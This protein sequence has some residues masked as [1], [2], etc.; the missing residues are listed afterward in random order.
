MLSGGRL[1]IPIFYH[2]DARLQKDRSQQSDQYILIP[3]LFG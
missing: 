3:A 1:Q 2:T